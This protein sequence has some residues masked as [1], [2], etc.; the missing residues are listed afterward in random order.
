MAIEPSSEHPAVERRH[1]SPSWL[2]SRALW[3]GLSII[4]MWLAVLFVGIFGGDFVSSSSANGFTKIPV[5]V[6]LLP[7]VL[8]A[9]IAVG[10]RGFTSEPE[11]R[12]PAPDDHTQARAQ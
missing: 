7:F 12:Q 8:P 1:A 10:R 9:T 4:V 3:A 2:H 11:A 5:V 6:F